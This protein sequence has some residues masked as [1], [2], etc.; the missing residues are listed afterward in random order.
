MAVSVIYF[1][2]KYYNDFLC[3]MWRIDQKIFYIYLTALLLFLLST[4]DVPNV[5][6]RF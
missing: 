2:L 5:A 6:E 1:V 3:W 4:L